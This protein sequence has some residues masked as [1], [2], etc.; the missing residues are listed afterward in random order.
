M[1]DELQE[2]ERDRAF[3]VIW[4][5]GGLCVRVRLFCPIEWG[6]KSKTV[7][8]GGGTRGSSKRQRQRKQSREPQKW[9]EMEESDNGV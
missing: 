7:L 6:I 9:A 5:R 4:Q 3:V 8:W 1:R 2:R